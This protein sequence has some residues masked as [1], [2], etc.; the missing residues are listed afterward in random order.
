MNGVF[1]FKIVIQTIKD[2]RQATL[3]ITLLFMGMAVMYSGM[4]PSFKDILVEMTESGV[5]DSFSFFKGA[6]DM[7][8]YVGFLNLELYQIFWLMILAIIMGFIA[9][10]SI[11]KEIEGKTID[12]L[13][14]NPISRKQII[15]EKFVGL[16][17]MFLII[18]IGTMIAVIG[19]TAAI[20]EEL[21]FTNLALVHIVSIPYFF[22]VMSIG[23]L[24]SV[25]LNEKMKAAIVMI[26]II[27]G[28]YII[29]SISQMTTNY[30][31]IGYASL[32]RYFNPYDA[33]KF[34]EVDISGVL[35]LIAVTIVCLAASLI[36]FE[37][38]D[39]Q[40]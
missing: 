26:A 35:V 13:M 21:S 37:H 18:N 1:R 27:V 40:I 39:I 9:A 29:E 19:V 30:E 10:A 3:A 24:V 7:G 8:S 31:A 25:I 16:I 15:F 2:N 6:E 32:N 23:I 20:N 14:S 22:A 34:G 5:A 11:A 28:M 12:L 33:L 17:P 38:K 4:Y 36:Y